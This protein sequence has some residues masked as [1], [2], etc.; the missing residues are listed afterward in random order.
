M[1]T[2]EWKWKLNL[3]FYLSPLMNRNILLLWILWPSSLKRVKQA[4]HTFIAT[5]Y[6]L[7]L[8]NKIPVITKNFL[9][10]IILFS[11]TSKRRKTEIL[12]HSKISISHPKEFLI[13]VYFFDIDNKTHT[14]YIL[15][16]CYC[17]RLK[18]TY[19]HSLIWWI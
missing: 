16:Y 11:Q 8:N 14:W 1:D 18:K 9:S 19:L 2:S 13:I 12:R 7:L 17:L 5:W 15:S 6:W 3:F 4:F 10:H